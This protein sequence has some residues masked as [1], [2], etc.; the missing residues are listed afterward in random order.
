MEYLFFFSGYHD[1]SK[2]KLKYISPSLGMPN[3]LTN[4]NAY[5]ITNA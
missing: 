4:D 1:I 5:L 2:L 3:C